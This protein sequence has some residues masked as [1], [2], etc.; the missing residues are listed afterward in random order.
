M[1]EYNQ[2]YGCQLGEK[3][4][5]TMESDSMDAFKML[6]FSL[7]RESLGDAN[8]WREKNHEKVKTLWRT[9]EKRYWNK[10]FSWNKICL[11]I[12]HREDFWVLGEEFFIENH[13]KTTSSQNNFLK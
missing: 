8:H 7:G 12:S 11:G 2:N 1:V 6:D 5:K 3:T 9:F 4:L 13:P 10:K